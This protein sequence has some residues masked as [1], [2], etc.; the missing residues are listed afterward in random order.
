MK[1]WLIQHQKNG[2]CPKNRLF[3][4]QKKRGLLL[5][6]KQKKLDHIFVQ[7]K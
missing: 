5:D 3:F 4:G 1:K 6:K 2:E 7:K